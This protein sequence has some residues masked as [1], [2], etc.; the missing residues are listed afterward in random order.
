MTTSNV[1]VYLSRLKSDIAVL[2]FRFKM[3]LTK[4]IPILLRHNPKVG[5]IRKL[6]S[7][8]DESD[9]L[10]CCDGLFICQRCT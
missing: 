2:K 8:D 5:N 7:N 9:G 6:L 1:L 10:G 3:K 4:I